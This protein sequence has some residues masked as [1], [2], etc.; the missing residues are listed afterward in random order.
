MI[1]MHSDLVHVLQQNQNILYVSHRLGLAH[2]CR[3]TWDF[4]HALC[5]IRGQS[6][7]DEKL[8]VVL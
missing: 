3:P 5:S 8:Q 2:E 1:N 4:Q 7:M 6:V